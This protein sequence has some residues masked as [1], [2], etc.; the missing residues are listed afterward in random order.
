M[1]ICNDI[2]KIGH[3]YLQVFTAIAVACIL[4]GC[5]LIYDDTDCSQSYNLVS[6]VYDKNM[7][8]A[9]AF[10]YEIKA[11]SLFAFNTETGKLVKRIDAFHDDLNARNETVLDVAPGNY[12]IIVWAG[13]YS[14]SFSIA[15]SN[16]RGLLIHDLHCRLNRLDEN[17]TA[18]VRKEIAA[19]WHGQINTELPYASPSKP[20]YIT[21]PLTKNTNTIRIVLQHISG[22]SV[23]CNDF[24]FTINDSNG[25][26]NYDNTLLQDDNI[27]YHPWY[28]YSGTVDINVNPSL[29]PASKGHNPNQSIIN[30]PNPNFLTADHKHPETR[31]TLSACLAEFTVCRLMTYNKPMLTV[32]DKKRQRVVLRVPVIDFVLLVKG[33]YNQHM[34]DQEYLDRQDEYNLTF[35]LDGNDNWLD[36]EIIINDWRII[37]HEIPIE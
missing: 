16:E 19:L 24:D 25:W 20:N 34:S 28:T 21:I 3:G 1:N 37:H 32:S 26:M 18:H 17:G 14:K 9:D 11:I 36:T 5:D 27:Y 2:Q 13:E 33:F 6:F 29:P 31:V 30:H 15:S 8:F 22:E 7:K 10:D 12:D 4:Q 35:F 23:N